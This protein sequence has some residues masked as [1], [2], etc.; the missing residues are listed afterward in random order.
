M[1]WSLSGVLV[2]VLLA[3]CDASSTA[4]PSPL[5]G[6]TPAASPYAGPMDLP[7]SGDDAAPVLARTGVAGRALECDGVPYTG[8]R[9]YFGKDLESVQRSALQVLQEA[10]RRGAVGSLPST[11]YRVERVAKGRTLFSYDVAGRTKVSVVAVDH[12][13]DAVGRAGW[14]M[15]PWAE[16]D[17][18]ELPA[19]Q[20]A[21][22]GIGVWQDRSGARVPVTRAQSV[23][24]PAHCDWQG[25]TFLLLGDRTYLRD[26]HG[27][28]AEHLRTTYR[29]GATVPP[30]AV[31]TGLHRDGRELWVDADAAYL[32]SLDDP[33]DVERWPGTRKPVLCA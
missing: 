8:Q 7:V 33:S 10:L 12:V 28:L 15:E 13:R 3:G 30:T 24:G 16:C 1:R 17:P 27:A 19:A 26:V 2:A 9:G 23:R 18:S 20:T 21:A 5:V 29:A 22:L 11:G 6:G 4:S 14:A 32:V 25:I 31:D